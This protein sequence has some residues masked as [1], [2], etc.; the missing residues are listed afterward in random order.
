MASRDILFLSSHDIDQCLSMRDAI[1]AMKPAFV[2]LSEGGAVVPQRQV[3]PMPESN[4]QVLS[5]PAYSPALKKCGLKFLTLMGHNP[6]QGLP[7]IHAV[8]LLADAE[9]GR[10][11]ALMDGE[12]LT[13]LRT[14]AASGVATELLAR[15]EA[16]TVVIFGAGIQGRTQL[17]GGLR[18]SSN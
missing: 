1:E 4:G 13:A 17:E 12:R 2:E 18:R 9:N 10:P 7:L 14:G 16:K 5:M 8:Y 3:V 6:G 15:P 11:L